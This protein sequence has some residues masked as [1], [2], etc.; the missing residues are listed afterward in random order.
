MEI[1]NLKLKASGLYSSLFVVIF[2]LM[3]QK[4]AVG[5]EKSQGDSLFGSQ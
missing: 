5:A 3:F 4:I 1:K 2:P